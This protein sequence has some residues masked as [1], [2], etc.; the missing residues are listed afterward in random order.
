MICPS[1]KREVEKIKKHKLYDCQCGGKLL[2]VEVKKK[3]EIFDLSK[4]R[5]EK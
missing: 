1:C 4:K 5:E 3:I 2:A